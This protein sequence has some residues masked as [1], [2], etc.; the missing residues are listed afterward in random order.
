MTR[1]QAITVALLGCLV[2]AIA[3][4]D[5]NSSQIT[6]PPIP[7]ESAEKAAKKN[8]ENSYLY[9]LWKWATHDAITVYTFFLALFTAVLSATAIV[10]IRY[11]IRADY[12]ARRSSIAARRAANASIRQAR[13]AEAA[14]TQVERPYIFIWGMFSHAPKAT[15]TSTTGVGL[16]VVIQDN[17]AFVYSVSNRG[18]LAAVVE[19]VLIACGYENNGRCPPLIIIGDHKFV[20]MPILSPEKDIENI[21]HNVAWRELDRANPSPEFRDGL[22]FRVVIYYRGPFT[23]GHETSQC[24]QWRDRAGIQGWVEDPRYTYAK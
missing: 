16:P 15:F 10:Q 3:W 14:L 1:R 21:T 2:G 4:F 8:S 20:Q 11:L 9:D 7:A 24:W 18:K 12:V 5:R 17:A 13:I 19:T 22:I 6:A 23:K